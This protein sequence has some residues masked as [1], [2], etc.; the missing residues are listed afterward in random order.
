MITCT[1]AEN[2]VPLVLSLPSVNQS[3]TEY[4]VPSSCVRQQSTVESRVYEFWIV[5]KTSCLGRRVCEGFRETILGTV[6]ATPYARTPLT[7]DSTRSGR[8][9]QSLDRTSGLLP[10]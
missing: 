10:S 3:K 7:F 4:A 5:N 6:C 2:G 9:A 8:E 1:N